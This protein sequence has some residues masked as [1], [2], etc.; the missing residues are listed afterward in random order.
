MVGSYN[1]GDGKTTG[2]FEFL[3]DKKVLESEFM[4]NKQESEEP[5]PYSRGQALSIPNDAITSQLIP[6][7]SG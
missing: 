5:R 7:K 2:T 4:K 1:S 3:L 6:S